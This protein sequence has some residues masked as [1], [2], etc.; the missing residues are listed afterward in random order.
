MYVKSTEEVR[1]QASCE[2]INYWTQEYL[3][4]I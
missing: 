1:K 3:N 4:T 2:L